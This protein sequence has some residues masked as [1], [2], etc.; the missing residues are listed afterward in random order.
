VARRNAGA[1]VDLTQAH[2]LTAGLIQAL[3][4]PPGKTQAFLRDTKAPG[5]R[6]RVTAT[7]AKSFV[8]EA[9]LRGKTLRRT[10]GSVEAWSIEAARS[11]AKRLAVDV[12]KGIDPR[13]V[14]R[15]ELERKAREQAAAMARQAEQAIMATTVSQAW[16]HYMQEGKPRGKAA[17]KPRYRLD[18]ER[19][20]AAGGVEL[21][22]GKGT[23]KPGHL[24]PLMARR[25]VDIDADAIRDWFAVE[26]LRAPVQAA[27][28]AAMF[29]GFLRWCS[30]RK[31]F[32]TLVQRD[33]ARAGELV[34]LLPEKR[35]RTDALEAEQLKP[36]FA[37]TD[38]LRS[39]VARAYLQALVLTGARREEMAA[40]R[41][42]DVD[43]RWRRIVLADKVG[44]RR[45]IPLTPY[46]TPLLGK[47]PREIFADG[48]AN[49]Y[50][51]ASS[52][53]KSGRIAEPRA[54]HA[55]VLADAGIPHVSIHGLR[56]TF[57]LM[58]EAAGAPAG[59]IAQV[60]GH[61]PSAV[62][63]GYKPRS[64]DAL[65][66]YLELVERFILDRAGVKFDSCGAST[67]GLRLVASA[68]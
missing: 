45:V 21:K 7:G 42:D 23:T 51:F 19:A 58:G 61:R 12:D 13:E 8:Y 24:W 41:W 64:I 62:H 20:A 16:S 6:V 67:P 14:E 27:R 9:K 11:Q 52:I 31:E 5:L 26:K 60:M 49:P 68:T 30:S 28:A 65:R 1:A 55:D 48:K 39:P 59:A 17:W 4:C 43:F 40:L 66:P 15:E 32:R 33:A 63:E 47:L 29:S 22:R 54:P 50:V 57:A 36:W 38:K 3:G 37:G 46:M 18:L 2:D 56:R 53:S 34:D 35:R 44:D 25:L 10:I